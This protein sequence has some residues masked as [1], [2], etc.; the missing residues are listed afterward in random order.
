[1]Y[2]IDCYERLSEREFLPGHKPIQNL[3]SGS[4]G[5][6]CYHSP[7]LMLT[8][9]RYDDFFDGVSFLFTNTGYTP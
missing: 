3:S 9:A 5:I 8:W 2:A 7:D 4:K 6:N 1:M